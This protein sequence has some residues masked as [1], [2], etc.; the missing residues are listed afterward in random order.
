[1]ALYIITCIDKPNSL[2]LRLATRQAHLDYA[3]N[4]VDRML[5]GGPLLSDDG[6]TMQGSMLILDLDDPAQ[7][8]DYLANDPY[9]QAGLFET[10]TVRRYKKMLP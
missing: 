9:N 1:M 3:Q 6:Q 10:V 4:W 2:D 7:I 8:D 5:V